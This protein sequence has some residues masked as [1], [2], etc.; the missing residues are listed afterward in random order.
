M[1]VAA[2]AQAPKQIGGFIGGAS[3]ITTTPP[4][5]GGLFNQPR[6]VAVFEGTDNDPSTDKIFVTSAQGAER[7]V[8]RLDADGNFEL[9]WGKD[10]IAAGALGDTGSGYEVCT[11][12]ADCWIGGGNSSSGNAM[13]GSFGGEFGSSA[14]FSHGPQGIAVNQSTGHVYV[15][16]RGNE[17]VQEFDLGG[18]F[19]RAWGWD[20]VDGVANPGAP[21]DVDSSSF[22][23]CTVA[24]T[25]KAGVASSVNAPVGQFGANT[26]ANGPG[27]AVH[28]TTGDVFVW[29]AGNRRVQQFTQTGARV[30]A[31][32]W[33]VAS[34]VAQFQACETTCST[35]GTAGSENGRFANAS[36]NGGR[37]AV[38]SNGIVYVGDPSAAAAVGGANRVVRFDSDLA[39]GA[40]GDA[41]AALHAPI[42][43]CA[44][45]AGAPLVI[46]ATLGLK[47]DSDTDGGGV[48]E[49]RL[50][51]LRRNPSGGATTVQELDI[52]AVP[53]D[54]ITAS[55][56]DSPLGSLSGVNGFGVNGRL[57]LYYVAFGQA[58]FGGNAIQHGLAV[59]AEPGPGVFSA[60]VA[61]PDP[62]GSSTAT[63]RGEVNPDGGTATY[64]FE[65]AKGG[66]GF[67]P[68]GEARYA[69]GT[70]PVSV[71]TPLTGLDPNTL[72]RIR[73]RATKVTGPATANTATSGELVFVTAPAAPAVETVTASDVSDTEALLVG[74]VNPNGSETSYRFQY[75]T[76][77]SYGNSAPDPAGSAGSATGEQLVSA[78]LTQLIPGQGY[79][80]RLC[81]TNSQGTICGSDRSFT[82]KQPAAVSH[83]HP[84]RGYELVTPADKVSGP[85]VGSHGN[86]S[87]LDGESRFRVG[88]PSKDGERLVSGTDSGPILTPGAAVMVDDTALSGR[89]SDQV[90][91]TSRSAYSRR[92]HTVSTSPPFLALQDANDDLSLLFFNNAGGQV[93]LFP[94]M[95]AG[96]FGG[97]NAYLRDWEDRWEL[98]APTDPSTQGLPGVSSVA[99]SADGKTAVFNPGS[100]APGFKGLAGPADPTHDQLSGNAV[101]LDDVS[102]GL[103]NTFPGAGIRTPL[104]SCTPGTL[105]PNRLASGKVDTGPCPAP[106]EFA[107]GEFRAAGLIDRRGTDTPTGIDSEPTRNVV[108]AD[109]SR[110]F[111]LAPDPLAADPDCGIGTGA[112]TSCPPQLYVRQRNVDGSV[113]TRWISRP[114]D[115]LLG[116]QDTTLTASAAFAGASEDGS[117]VYFKTASPL[118]I[119]DP[120]AGSSITTGA[121]QSSSVD[122]YRYELP[123]GPDGNPSTPDADPA[124]GTLA[125][126]SAGPSG[127]SD[128]NVA[129]SGASAPLRFLSADGD[130]AYFTCAAPLDGT[131]SSGNGTITS[132]GGARTTEDLVNLYLYDHT[133]TGAERWGFVARLPRAIPGVNSIAPCATTGGRQGSVV[134]ATGEM[135]APGGKRLIVV[136]EMNCLRGSD[137]ARFV[138]LWTQARLTADDPDGVSADIYAYDAAADTLSRITATEDGAGGSYICVHDDLNTALVDETVACHGDPGF[139]AFT[140]LAKSNLGVVTDPTDGDRVAFFESRSRLVTEDVDDEMDVYEWRSGDLSLISTG[141]D[142]VGAYYSGNSADGEDVFFRTDARL[143]W[144]DIDGV[145]D[146]YDARVGGGIPQP[147]PAAVCAVLAGS[148][149]G[150]GAGAV[151]VPGPRTSSPGGGNAGRAERMT[152]AVSE[153]SAKARR[154]ASRTGR[155]VLSVRASGAGRVTAVARGRLGG[156]VRRV[157]SR[158]VR[159]QA[160]G[161]AKLALRLSRIARRR[162]AAGRGL[163]VRVRI[164]SAGARGRSMTVRLPGVRS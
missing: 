52:P 94:E 84:G 119:D 125:R 139:E 81:A 100:P 140:R 33:G 14:S 40:A 5:P 92:N 85:G 131:G 162:L 61:S 118:T 24:S 134:R 104:G 50:V 98:I 16:D 68:V 69:S 7:R 19:V 41:T 137:D 91:W 83:P 31:W 56:Q 63:G 157:A 60:A 12:A 163:S 109:G 30:R 136:S 13:V 35:T 38:D 101:Y 112:D 143:S 130:R 79:H 49:E 115:A 141:V 147:A 23:V 37:L 117:V 1:A 10:T 26:A 152:L 21:G 86:H 51:V 20:V 74:R 29:D 105:I 34:G 87:H 43:C 28:P 95:T 120:N 127:S 114:A 88:F 70:L 108:S 6:D 126:V 158:S 15:F 71:S 122:L 54:S 116:G 3:S 53:S 135:D 25:C 124:G 123:P 47:I 160:A 2:S 146:V 11:V 65:V 66:G 55:F 90:G 164:S 44:P 67:N 129:A 27:V 102:A 80:Y 107:P 32:G 59:V 9:A 159:L 106:S 75:G 103:S 142:G 133:K 57:G 89:V 45:T 155:L 132:P 73:L 110:V 39:P 62:V 145:A 22:E 78:R 150:D 113:S 46:G 36:S 151:S 42:G 156:R 4:G 8:Q 93:W 121:A 148:C 128:C 18:G 97:S 99:P 77:A 64:V 138:T 17:R 76:T 154:R 96:G 58:T 82:T 149:H 111:F 48:D 72:Y 144:Q 161:R 153:L